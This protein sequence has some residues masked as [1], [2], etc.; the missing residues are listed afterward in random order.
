MRRLA[1]VSLLLVSGCSGS[2]FWRYEQDTLTLPGLP[3]IKGA[4]P[5]QPSGSSE[6]YFRA[7]GAKQ[8][9]NLPVQ[10][11]EA[12]DVWPGPPAP[13]PT[14][15]DLQKQQSAEITGNG[16][17]LTPLPSLPSLPGYEISQQEPSRAPPASALTAPGRPMHVPP[18]STLSPDV[19]TTGSAPIVVPNGNGTS[20]VISPNGQVST[21]PTP[22]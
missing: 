8:D 7:L 4:N 1:L 20:T 10:L 16:T 5:N 9:A 15:K 19:N 11:T 12:G 22:K 18:T 21:I 6:N 2:G 3:F 13:V 17:G 14:L